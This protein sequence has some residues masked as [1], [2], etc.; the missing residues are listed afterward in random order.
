MMLT[1][2][3]VTMKNYTDSKSGKKGEF[4]HTLGFAIVEIKD[5]STFFVRQVTAHHKTGAFSDL[6]FHVD[7][8]KVNK[9]KSIAGIVWGDLHSGHHD[10]QVRRELMR[11]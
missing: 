3:A 9:L 11:T 5:K 6:Y 1:T 2:G 7:N 4:H 8:A 10:P